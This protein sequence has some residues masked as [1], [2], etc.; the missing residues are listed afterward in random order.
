MGAASYWLPYGGR[1][2]AFHT[3]WH[4]VHHGS[5]FD[6]F[7]QYVL[8]LFLTALLEEEDD[9]CLVGYLVMRGQVSAETRH[10]LLLSK[11]QEA[12]HIAH[13]HLASPKCRYVLK[14]E[15]N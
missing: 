12:L 1:S 13:L 7:P 6:N 2:N 4:S 5:R 3:Q 14:R 9:V 8:P 15:T 10:V 11:A